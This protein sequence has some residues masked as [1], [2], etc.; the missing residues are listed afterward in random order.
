MLPVAAADL[1]V[2][3]LLDDL[4]SQLARADELVLQAPPGAGKTTLVPLA[5]LDEPWLAGRRILLLE[6]RRIAAQAA[7]ARMAELLGEA[8]GQTVGY[9]IRLDSCV[10]EQTRIEVI[11]E[12]IL[13]RRLQGD[14]GLEEVGLVIFDE[15]HERN[16]DS[17]LCLALALQGRAHFRE[18]AP[19]KLLVMSATLDGESV[20]QLLGGAPMLTSAG[21]QHPVETRFGPAHELRDPIEPRVVGAVQAALA[22]GSGSL[23]V[24]LPGQREINRVARDLAALLARSGNAEVLLAPL[25]GGLSL[26]R[27][28]QAIEPA[29]PGQRKVVLATNVAETSLTIEGIDTV[30]DSGLVREGVFDPATGVTRLATRRISRSSAAQREGR[31]GRLGPGRC[32]RLWSEEQ[33]RRLVARPDPEILHADLA[34]LALQLLAWGV[35]EPSDLAW[36]DPPPAA[37][38]AQALSVLELCGAIY[39]NRDG[40]Y[41]VTPQGVRLAQMPMHPRLGHMLLVGCDIRALENACLLAALLSERNPLAGRGADLA[42]ALAVLMGEERLAPELDGW[43]RRVWAQA[44]RFAR[45]GLGDEAPPTGRTA[46]A[47]PQDTILGVLLASAW[48]DRIA[49]LRTGGDGT[50]YLMSNGRAAELPPGD[51]LA[52]RQWLAVAEIGSQVGDAVDRIYSAAALD[53]QAFQG[54][55]L[56]LVAEEDR[57]EWDYRS[58]QFIARRCRRVGAVELS[59]EPL[60]EVPAA[61]RGEALLG[62]VRKRGLGILPW[63]PRLQQ[64]RSRVML[65]HRLQAQA[66][67][68]P[69]PDLSDEALLDTLEQWLLP[70]LD[71]VR[72]LEDFQALDL[73]AILQALLPWPLPLELERL[74][75]ERLAVP[76]G[77]SIPIDYSQDPPVLAVK[78]QEMFGCEETPTVAGG[79]V[80][81]LVH[82]LSPAQRPLQVTSD[83]A[84]FWRNGYPEVRREMKGRYPKHPW[85]EDPLQATPT[86]H[87]KQRLA[88][89][90]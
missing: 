25:Y 41:R 13:T 42:Q 64:W 37:A 88:A 75:P 18:G 2:V 24:F 65:L 11:T 30:I 21:R 71:E 59:S 49:R 44:R 26:R 3:S 12:G 56:P 17:D 36:L 1:P 4:K 22:E 31:A 77:S 73:K 16:L 19:L 61:A 5:L 84:S 74:A 23:L 50:R 35:E 55:L 90:S 52:G 29:P 34:P 67:G 28:R 72:R 79:R 68:N 10:S 27:Q 83:L 48:P 60:S 86:R 43:F 62:M 76:S 40:R 32:C 15:F 51:A 9:R 47:I 81:L 45:L 6:P 82:L 54:V 8:V 39:R 70:W 58:D 63:P 85:P 53:P 38:Y 69:W 46:V 89:E 33:H 14:P 78:L 7:A 57:V 80:M 87:T 20:A 66:P